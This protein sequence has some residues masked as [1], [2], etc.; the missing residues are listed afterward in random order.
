MSL[1]NKLADLAIF[2]LLET[3]VVRL[4][5]LLLWFILT[6]VL[7]RSEVGALG[8]GFGYW[9]LFSLLLIAPESIL[10]RDF[11]KIKKEGQVNLFIS[12]F[13]FFGILRTIVITFIATAIAIYLFIK[14][15][16]YTVS[17]CLL[18]ITI[19]N[20]LQVLQG[21]VRE[22]FKVD[23]KQRLAAAINFFIETF[24]LI[25]FSLVLY[26]TRSLFFYLA[27]LVIVR[28]IALSIW[29]YIFS[30]KYGP[31]HRVKFKKLYTLLMYTFKDFSLWNHFNGAITNFVY[32]IDTAVLSW[33]GMSLVVI[34][35]YSIAL[36]VANFFF[37]LPM[38]LQSVTTIA[39][40]N[41]KNRKK[42]LGI[43]IFLKYG[44]VLSVIQLLFFLFCG[45]WIIKF[46]AKTEGL[47]EAFRYGLLI[48]AGISILNAVR[49]LISWLAING[50]LRE[51][52]LQV[53]LP[54]GILGLIAYYGLGKLWGGLGVAFGN[55]VVYV[56]FTA[57]IFVYIQRHCPFKIQIQ[58]FTDEEK[59][60]LR[61]LL[62][63]I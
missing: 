62:K 19:A 39:L 45:K 31:P 13:L 7:P 4:S 10:Y 42:E 26:F 32:N 30:Q 52:F 49:P 59:T 57:V 56:F 54:T 48:M 58:L 8:L 40:S 22:L 33:L 44:I 14:Y 27:A 34:G 47:E 38:T 51:A 15:K 43:N 60:L 23:F 16:T 28:F 1:K 24:S 9:A 37:L 46:F 55:I 50:N 11:P 29:L 17:I 21:P 18:L 6:R 2:S 35:N 53:Y 63:K 41:L 20:C 3:I 36:R 12:S 61:G 5:R 25:A